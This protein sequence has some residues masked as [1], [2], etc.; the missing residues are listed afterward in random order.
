MS[1]MQCITSLEPS[2]NPV[3]RAY[4]FAIFLT[5]FTP[6]IIFLFPFFWP[7]L[8]KKCQLKTNVAGNSAVLGS[9]SENKAK[10]YEPAQTPFATFF[11][12]KEN[13]EDVYLGVCNST[14]L[15]N[16]LY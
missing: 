2:Y 1:E 9:S 6:T 13:T 11:P 3:H 7:L 15:K 10:E 4:W 12:Q 5:R 8:P 14:F 16:Q